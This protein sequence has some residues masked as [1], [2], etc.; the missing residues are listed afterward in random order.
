MLFEKYHRWFK[1][2]FWFSKVMWLYMYW[3][4]SMKYSFEKL[5]IIIMKRKDGVVLMILIYLKCVFHYWIDFASR[6]DLPF[7][8]TGMPQLVQ[9][10]CFIELTVW[11]IMLLLQSHCNRNNLCISIT[12]SDPFLLF[13]VIWQCWVTEL[14]SKWEIWFEY[15]TKAGIEQKKQCYIQYCSFSI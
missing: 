9:A 11:L 3:L 5:S 10:L 1:L 7:N 14:Y 2:L 4:G 8:Y 15:N 6:I 12:V 13:D